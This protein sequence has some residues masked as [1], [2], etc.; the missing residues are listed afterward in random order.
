MSLI[1]DALKRQQEEMNKKPEG[2]GA[3]N[4]LAKLQTPSFPPPS[5][6]QSK[7]PLRMMGQPANTPKPSIPPSMPISTQPPAP[8]PATPHMAQPVVTPTPPPIASPIRETP[9]HSKTAEAPS[10]AK[11]A[12]YSEQPAE[13]KSLQPVLL[14]VVA[15]LLI[16]GVGLYFARPYLSI[17]INP[18]VD[19]KRDAVASITPVLKP[20]P[21]VAI[22]TNKPA[23]TSAVPGEVVIPGTNTPIH[24]LIALPEIISQPATGPTVATGTTPVV[25]KPVIPPKLVVWP[26]IKMTGMVKLGGTSA[27]LINGKVVAAGETIEN[28]LLLNVTKEGALLSFEGEERMLRVG[29]TAR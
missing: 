8:A 4:P 19:N 23:V 10:E 9:A 15:L 13:K 22:E 21:V 1:Q 2:S 29:E 20:V 18:T 27:A 16:F 28:V 11:K 7:I 14:I 25:V 6:L 17:L 3:E 5:G 24:S 12:A 26:P